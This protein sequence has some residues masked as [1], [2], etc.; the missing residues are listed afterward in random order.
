MHSPLPLFWRC[1][2]PASA[3]TSQMDKPREQV[4]DKQHPGQEQGVRCTQTQHTPG[5]SETC[6]VC[7]ARTAVGPLCNTPS[8][9][10]NTHRHMP[11]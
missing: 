1:R 9:G 6:D 10:V 4:G 3:M 2:Q 5:S 7:Q 11:P 8:S